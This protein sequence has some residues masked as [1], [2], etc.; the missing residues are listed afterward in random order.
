MERFLK[1]RHC[2]YIRNDEEL[3][4]VLTLFSEH[5]LIWNSGRDAMHPTFKEKRCMFPITIFYHKGLQRLLY[6]RDGERDGWSLLY[7]E[8]LLGIEPVQPINLG[9]LYA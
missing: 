1:G 6:N 4:K 8:D 9:M 5:N 3:D 7:A 2:V